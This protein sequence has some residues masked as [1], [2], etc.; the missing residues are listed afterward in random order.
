MNK[1]LV[2][3]NVAL[4]L[5]VGFLFY[6]VNSKPTEEVVTPKKDSKSMPVTS[7]V[8]FFNF[9]SLTVNYEF[10]K[11]EKKKFEQLQN[12]W[13]GELSAKEQSFQ[14]RYAELEQK[15]QTMNQND[16]Q[17]AQ[18]ELGQMQ[19]TMAE[20]KQKAAED[21]QKKN[22]E[23]A[24]EMNKKLD[25]FLKTYN[26]KQQFDYILK[27]GEGGFIAY[28]KEALNITTDVINGLNAEYENAKKAKK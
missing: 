22:L 19:Q 26:Q 27:S 23:F 13:D 11:D 20:L 1:V 6:Q 3:I 5:A 15:A 12:R 7:K 4:V 28:G 18:M 24:T 8:A 10:I 9:D 2:G 25:S 17:Q 21:I 16:M 14:K